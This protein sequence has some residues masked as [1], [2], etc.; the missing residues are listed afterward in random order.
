MIVVPD[1]V[2]AKMRPFYSELAVQ[3]DGKTPEHL[4]KLLDDAVNIDA[5]TMLGGTECRV[6]SQSLV[7]LRQSGS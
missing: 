4:R 6:R 5:D 7:G 3:L 1:A 2:T